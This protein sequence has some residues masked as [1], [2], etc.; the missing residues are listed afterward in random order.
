MKISPNIFFK[1]AEAQHRFFFLCLLLMLTASSCAKVGDPLPPLPSDLVLVGD[2]RMVQSG[3]DLYLTF[4]HPARELSEIE[5]Y[6][7]CDG[8]TKGLDG[9]DPVITVPGKE[10]KIFDFLDRSFIPA[11]SGDGRAECVYAVRT[12]ILRGKRSGFS[13]QVTWKSTALPLTPVG[14]EIVTTEN[15]VYVEWQMPDEFK[16]DPEGTRPEFLLDSKAVTKNNFLN[17]PDFSFGEPLSL[18]VRTIDRSRGTILL[19]EPLAFDGFVPEDVFPPQTPAGLIVIRMADRVQLTWDD[20]S[21]T[22]LAGYF[23]Y[24]AGEDGKPQRI[25]PLLTIN[26]FVDEV[27]SE[28][29]GFIYSVS[30]VDKWDNESSP[31]YK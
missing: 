14:L 17:I 9:T 10:I 22:D 8:E 3:Q 27:S 7:L 15:Q 6:R 24:R 13:N 21:E 1:K 30:A 12:I 31:A 23:V 29:S 11:P 5:V 19:S 18:E 20:N 4:P 26:R 25:S 2:L 28:P 16:M